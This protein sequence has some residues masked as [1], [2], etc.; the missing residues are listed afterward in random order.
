MINFVNPLV[1]DVVVN[2]MALFS[3][4]IVAYLFWL[5]VREK[6]QDQLLQKARERERRSHWGYV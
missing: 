1:G 2:G 4:G 6:R 3:V 5:R